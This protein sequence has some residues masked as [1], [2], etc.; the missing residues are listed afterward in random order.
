MPFKRQKKKTYKLNNKKVDQTK[1]I[2][3]IASNKLT[4]QENNNNGKFVSKFY[5]FLVCR[6]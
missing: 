2:L 5:L 4:I 3:T 6:F 1:D